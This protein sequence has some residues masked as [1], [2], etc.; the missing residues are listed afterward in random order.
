MLA[1]PVTMPP[2][3]SRGGRGRSRGVAEPPRTP[4]RPL[5]FQI[6][7]QEDFS[8]EL[9]AIPPDS[10]DDDS[11]D[12][13][14]RPPIIISPIKKHHKAVSINQQADLA[15][16]AMEDQ[17]IIGKH[18]NIFQ[19]FKY[20]AYALTRCCCGYLALQCVQSL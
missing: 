6:A 20:S 18:A 17:E 7:T 13:H 5:I 16:W 14:S 4:Q 10:D 1:H 8:R 11:V 2:R 19:I 9:A 12:N 15:V 3:G